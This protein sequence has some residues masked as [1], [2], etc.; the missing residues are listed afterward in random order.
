[1]SKPRSR[2]R[3]IVEPDGFEEKVIKIPATEFPEPVLPGLRGW[4]TPDGWLV[5]RV[6]YSADP[7]RDE[8]WAEEFS[9]GYR[10]G[11][12]GRDWQR[13]LEIDFGSYEGDP[14]YEF[15]GYASIRE[16][17]Y[18]PEIP[19]WRGWDFGYRR[20]A[21]VFTQ[22]YPDDTFVQLGELFPTGQPGVNGISTPDF[23]QVVIRETER[24]FP[25]AQDPN[26]SAGVNDYCDP[27]GNQTKETSDYSSIEYLQMV[28]I[29]PEWANVGRKNRVE[30]LRNYIE[31]KHEDE[32]PKFLIHPR[33]QLTIKALE[34]GYHY[35]EDSKGGSDRD[36]P[37]HSRNEQRKPYVHLMDALEYVA[38]VELS[39]EN[40]IR[41]SEDARRKEAEKERVIAGDTVERLRNRQDI[42]NE[43]DSDP[44]GV[45]SSLDELLGISIDLADAFDPV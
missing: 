28:G 34:G 44:S 21:V 4:R 33:C 26:K 36:M 29:E 8:A 39:V 20:P 2:K 6:H 16:V 19:L 27:A 38:A 13:E 5:M 43:L 14:V 37:D 10:G 31:D 22:L 7:D 40:I 24:L 32:A 25:E 15:N 23:A 18:N 30:Y 45:E 9:K 41:E 35:P 12:R 42:V 11:T 1:M 3:N 17:R